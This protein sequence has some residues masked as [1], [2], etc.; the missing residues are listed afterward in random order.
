M[1]CGPCRPIYIE[2]YGSRIADLHVSTKV[3]QSLDLAEVMP[4]ACIEGTAD[5]IQ[6][7][8][9]RDGQ[10]VG[11]ETVDI[12]NGVAEANFITKNPKLWFPCGYGE[13][14]LYSLR[15]T[16]L[17][18]DAILDTVSKRFG[19][20]RAIMVQHSLDNAPGTSFMFEINSI[21]IFCGGSN[22]IPADSFLTRLSRDVYY[23]WVQMMAE[24][25][26]RMLRVWGGGIYE[27]DAFYDACDELGIL[28]W[29]DFMFACG[30][31]PAHPEFLH[32]VKQEAVANVTRLRHHPSIV[33]WAGNNEDYQYAESE[34]L[35]Y[36]PG[37]E[38]QD[39]WLESTFPARFIYEKIL[40]DVTAE[41]VPE[42]YYHFGSPHGGKS[43]VDPTIGDIHQWNV[44]HGTQERY[45]DFNKLS[46]RFVS[47]FG[48]QALP[49][50]KTVDQF[51][52]NPEDPEKYPES[53][54]VSFHNKAA[55][56][57]RRLGIYLAE[58]ICH[59]FE[60][61]A[62]YIYCTQVMQAECITSAFT[63]WK[64]DWKGPGK[65]YCAGALAWQAN[66]CW[67][68]TSWSIADYEL[69]PKLSYYAVKREM[70]SVTIGMRRFVAKIPADKYTR[71]YF[72]TIYKIEL[73]ICNL[74][75]QAH[76]L[77]ISISTANLD[78]GIYT[79]HPQLFQVS[80]LLPNR[81]TEVMEFEIPVLHKDAGEELQTAV[82][83]TL[84]GPENWPNKHTV[85][86]PEPLKYAHLPPNSA[87]DMEI[88]LPWEDL[89]E[90]KAGVLPESKTL[91]GVRWLNIQCDVPLKAVSIEF[92]GHDN[93]AGAIL[94]D[95]GFDVMPGR[96]VSVKVRGLQK[97]EDLRAKSTYLGCEG[98][99]F[100]EVR[101]VNTMA[102]FANW[103]LVG[104]QMVRD[105]FWGHRSLLAP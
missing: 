96:W 93:R 70:E 83:A 37:E 32:L 67:P 91:R 102:N 56:H 104:N 16:L 52:G 68:C 28:V 4:R 45:Q 54:T 33:L 13:Q 18:G 19:I 46:G 1:T 74:D 85:N 25:N 35:G 75:L 98:G 64:R 59:D 57:D 6:F 61:F 77:G 76:R 34:G 94:E 63:S 103:I 72:K 2:V 21:P 69:R 36:V 95:N 62:Y 9:S 8:V 14:S 80:K 12:R 41:L 22:W 86:W 66:D 7:E 47:E 42:T 43:T 40:A 26:Q 65:E 60:P 51:F 100:K 89:E 27:N 105:T 79:K 48:M 11:K 20:R 49:D 5:Q 84:V 38:S 15:A 87:V 23:R 58:N 81:S 82:C 55:G 97:V 24:G 92:E 31:Y 17:A 29:Q 44:W 101:V 3:P 99:A 90:T 30:N 78:T 71:A 50:I 10:I 88:S 39:K 53:S 73:W